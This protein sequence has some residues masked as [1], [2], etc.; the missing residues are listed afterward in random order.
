[1]FRSYEDHLVV[2]VSDGR[3][4]TTVADHFLTDTDDPE[5]PDAKARVAERIKEEYADAR[6]YESMRVVAQRTR[7]NAWKWTVQVMVEGQWVERDV[8]LYDIYVT[9]PLPPSYS[10]ELRDRLEGMICE[11]LGI[12]PEWLSTSFIDYR[13]EDS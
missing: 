6:V 13:M 11:M 7:N 2:G 12:T 10:P 8:L 9:T 1:M 4:Y 3:I 5:S